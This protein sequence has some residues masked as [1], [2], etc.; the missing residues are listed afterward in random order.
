MWLRTFFGTECERKDSPKTLKGRVR[1]RGVV[2]QHL[3]GSDLRRLCAPDIN[4]DISC[5]DSDSKCVIDCAEFKDGCA[6]KVVFDSGAR[7]LVLNC[8]RE[9]NPLGCSVLSD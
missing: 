7:S 3:R 4:G 8:D 2:G 5:S 1:L 6:D 9:T